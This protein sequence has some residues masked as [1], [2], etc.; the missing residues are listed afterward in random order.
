MNDIIYLEGLS[1]DENHKLEIIRRI[2]HFDKYK[3]KY[4]CNKIENG[5]PILETDKLELRTLGYYAET[6]T[7]SEI[8]EWVNLLYKFYEN[9]L[10][11]ESIELEM[12][13]INFIEEITIKINNFLL[14]INNFLNKVHKK[15]RKIIK[16]L[17]V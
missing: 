14:R 12:C 2:C 7:V 17:F 13:L 16:K 9:T 10:I 1:S 5:L 11:C 8:K 3:L 6:F 4:L 15:C